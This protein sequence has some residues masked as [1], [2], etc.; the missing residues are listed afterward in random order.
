MQTVL[1]RCCYPIRLKK[2]EIP[3][4][5]GRPLMSLKGMAKSRRAWANV[6]CETKCSSDVAAAPQAAAAPQHRAESR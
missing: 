5:L 6:G 4:Q 2:Q 1:P 3:Q